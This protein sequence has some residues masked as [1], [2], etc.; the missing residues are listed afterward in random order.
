VNAPDHPLSAGRCCIR[1][2][3]GDAQTGMT[4]VT[5]IDASTI[6]NP[7][8]GM[9]QFL[10]PGQGDPTTAHYKRVAVDVAQAIDTSVERSSEIAKAGVEAREQKQTQDIAQAQTLN[11]DGPSGA[12]MKIG[13][14]TIASSDSGSSGG[15]DGGGGGAG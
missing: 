4:D 14:R 15:G 9:P 5:R 13:G 10:I 3:V 6:T 8:T 12:T 7:Q 2:V 1:H 11:Q